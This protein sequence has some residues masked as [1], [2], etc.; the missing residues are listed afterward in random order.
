MNAAF[1]RILYSNPRRMGLE[2]TNVTLVSTE[3]FALAKVAA[4]YES[5]CVTQI[6]AAPFETPKGEAPVTQQI[7][8]AR[9]F[10]LARV[11]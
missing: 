10:R 4:A 8:T 1:R 6:I 2:V 3:P 5:A 7:G 9:R 11:G